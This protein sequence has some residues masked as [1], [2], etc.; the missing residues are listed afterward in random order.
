MV[1]AAAMLALQQTQ[2]FKQLQLVQDR[3]SLRTLAEETR[4]K[5]LS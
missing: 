4:H 1:R 5:G 3:A 2:E